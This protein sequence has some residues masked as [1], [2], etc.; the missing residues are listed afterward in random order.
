MSSAIFVPRMDTDHYQNIQ[1][2]IK[3]LKKCAAA[4]EKGELSVDEVHKMVNLS[5]ELYERL[6]V[7]RY[8]AID[9]LV[10]EDKDKSVN[11]RI[12][13]SGKVAQNQTSLIDAIDEFE[14]TEQELPEEAV[15]ETVEEAVEEIPEEVHI[16]F[17]EV[18]EVEVEEVSEVE[19]KKATAITTEEDQEDVS[20][21]DKMQ[22][23]QSEESLASK[24]ERGPLESLKKA[25]SLNQKFQFINELFAGESEQYD[26][27]IKRIDKLGSS[28][29][30]LDYT[31]KD[32]GSE[33]GWDL[34]SD[35]VLQLVDL[36][37]RRFL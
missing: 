18:E 20:I 4:L 11:F 2:I 1:Q 10:K 9:H 26:K 31:Q 30:A 5:R 19:P 7:L 27:A 24:L 32:L 8:K 21:N 34:E 13:S 15:E 14:S 29:E 37:E 16:D 17:E 35:L 6:V 28:E 36:I 33:H 22:D 3:S 12:G 23:L 25:I